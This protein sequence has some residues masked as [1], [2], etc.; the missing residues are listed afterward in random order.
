MFQPI[1]VP[2]SLHGVALIPVPSKSGHPLLDFGCFPPRCVYPHVWAAKQYL[3]H[4]AQV[5]MRG[6]VMNHS[7]YR[8]R[9]MNGMVT[10]RCDRVMK[11]L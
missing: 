6:S 8:Q 9:K 11:C 4:Y 2:L 5:E 7:G 10:R 1:P 3:N